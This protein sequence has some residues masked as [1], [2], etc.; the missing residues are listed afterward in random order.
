[1]LSTRGTWHDN[2]EF[3]TRPRIIPVEKHNYAHPLNERQECVVQ[4]C[5]EKVSAYTAPCLQVLG[6]LAEL[7]SGSGTTFPDIFGGGFNAS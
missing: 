5:E 1:M 7:T 3:L 2:Q 4:K 6:T